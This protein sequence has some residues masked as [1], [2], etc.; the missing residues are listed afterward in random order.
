MLQPRLK[1]G[2]IFLLGF[3][4][5]ILIGCGTTAT[6]TF[7]LGR[8]DPI[9]QLPQ[10]LYRFKVTGNSSWFHET[11]FASGWLPAKAVDPL[12]ATVGIDKNNPYA[13]DVHPL[14]ENSSK[15]QSE[16]K[17]YLEA[18]RTMRLFGPE[19]F[20]E[21]PKDL[22]FVVVMSANPNKFFQAAGLLAG[23]KPSDEADLIRLV[24]SF[25]TRGTTEYIDLD[26]KVGE[27]QK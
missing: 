14:G 22:R 1:T 7:Y 27:V 9:N 5:A 8:F 2:L 3:S 23:N 11:H 20:L 24:N 10:E 15:G 17:N 18:Y 21:V 4:T 16:S 25:R 13:R 6:E 19:A 26:K 12:E